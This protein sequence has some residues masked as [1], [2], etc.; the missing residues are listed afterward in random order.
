MF[1]HALRS[2]HRGKSYSDEIPLPTT[3]ECKELKNHPVE[4]RFVVQDKWWFN[5]DGK[6]R[7]KPSVWVHMR[8]HHRHVADDRHACIQVSSI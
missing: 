4:L 2:T 5:P 1:N 8:E 6:V 3:F 7:R